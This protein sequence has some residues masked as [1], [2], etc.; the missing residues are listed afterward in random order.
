MISLGLVNLFASMRDTF[1]AIQ[2]RRRN[3]VTPDCF[4]ARGR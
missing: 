3:H 2:G 4:Q 1:K